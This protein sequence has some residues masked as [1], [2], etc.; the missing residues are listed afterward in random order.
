MSLTIAKKLPV[1]LILISLGVYSCSKSP[2]CNGDDENKDD[3]EQSFRIHDFPM[4]VEAYVNENGTMV[5]RTQEELTAILDS[6]C[7]NLPEAGYSV[8]PPEIDFSQH[9]LL[10]FWV[11]GGGCDVKYIREVTRKDDAKKYVYRIKVKECGSCDMLRY[12][13]NLVLV[14]QVPDDYSVEFIKQ[15]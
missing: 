15:E 9:S 14:P 12:D 2:V 7:V 6:G 5:I 1:L 8:A 3:I 13:A 11:T 10:G 4:C